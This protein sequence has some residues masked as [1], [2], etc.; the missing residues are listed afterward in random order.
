MFLQFTYEKSINYHSDDRRH[1]VDC[2]QQVFQQSFDHIYN[3]ETLEICI[4][5]MNVIALDTKYQTKWNLLQTK[6]T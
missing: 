6:M 1:V 5:N 3:L 2:E 4:T